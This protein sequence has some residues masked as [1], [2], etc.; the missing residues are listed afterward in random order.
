VRDAARELGHL[1]AALDVALGIRN[2]LAVLTGE[3]VGER[4]HLPRDQVKELHHD[5][6]AALRVGA[7]PGGLGGAG[8]LDGGPHLGLRGQRHLRDHLTGHWLID[9]ADAAGDS[10]A[11][12]PADEMP[13]PAHAELLDLYYL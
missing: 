7:R 12:P 9:V 10:F 6:G 11:M 13:D 2:R 4:V 3:K 1:D 5:A 8:I